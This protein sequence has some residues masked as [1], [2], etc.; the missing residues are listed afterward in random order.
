MASISNRGQKA[1]ITELR[2]DFKLY[3]EAINDLYHETNNPDGKFPINMA[4]NRMSWTIL[5]DKI[6]LLLKSNEIPSWVASYTGIAGQEDFVK[7][8]SSFMSKFLCKT[9]I[10]PDHIICSAGATAVYDLLS[11]V[12]CDEEEVCLIPAPSYPVYTQ[13]IANRSTVERHDVQSHYELLEIKDGL[14]LN[15]QQLD[16]AREAVMAQGKKVSMLILTS[17]DNP[18]GGIYSIGQLEIIAGW[19]IENEIH[20]VVNELY[21][22]SIIDE[23]HPSISQDYSSSIKF[24][25]FANIMHKL[26]SD[27]LHLTYGLSKDLGISGFRVG[28]VYSMNEE[29]R[30]AYKNLNAPHLVSNFTQW[31]LSLLLS[32]FDFIESYVKENKLRLTERY[33][34]VIS[35]LRDNSVAYVPSRGSLFIWIDLSPWLS[36]NTEDAEEVLWSNI[37]YH[38]GVLLTPG[39]G[40]G[41]Q[42]KGHYRIVYSF[43]DKHAMEKA[44]HRL[45]NYLQ[46]LK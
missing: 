31:I 35:I 20:L 27:Y 25:S 22:L 10:D 21:G 8:I 43:L 12:L 14:C 18:T 19:C 42:K 32:D 28:V 1:A 39:R 36:E 7:A 37:Y 26:R 41:N 4:E 40:F 23:S 44:M 24:N 11:W 29:F 33:A 5:S 38:T 17:P 13:D 9:K 15:I 34:S 30:L 16:N 2:S 3:F 45:M 46:K 6:S